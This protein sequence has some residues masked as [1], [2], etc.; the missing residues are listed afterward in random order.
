[1]TPRLALAAQLLFGVGQAQEAE[2]GVVLFRPSPEALVRVLPQVD[3]TRV[4]LVVHENQA[5]L[6]QQ[7]E[8]KRTPWVLDMDAWSVGGGTWFMVFDLAREDLGVQVTAVPPRWELRLVPDGRTVPPPPQTVPVRL[9]IAGDVA[10]QPGERGLTSLH[11]LDGD[12]AQA[13]LDATTFTPSYPVWQPPKGRTAEAELLAP[14]EGDPMRAIDRYRHVLTG[15]KVPR[16]QAMALYQLGHAHLDAGLYR[17]AS[18]YLGRLDEF[19]GHFPP[20]HGRLAQSR[21]ALAAGQTDLARSRCT[22]AAS[23]GARSVHVLECLGSVALATG[24]PAPSELARA[25]AARTA[26]AE[27]LLLAAQLFQQDHRHGEARKLL[28]GV[29]PVLEGEL[30]AIARLSLGDSLFAEGDLDGARVAWG[31]VT[32]GGELGALVRERLRLR[33]M[34][35]AGPSAWP[36]WLPELYRA[37]RAEGPQGAEALYTLSQVS[38]M[39]GDLDGAADHLAA[40]LDRYGSSL[41]RSD[42]P[43]RLWALSA[44][45]MDQLARAERQLELAAFHE[46]HYSPRLRPH[47]DDTGPLEGV[48][49]AYEALGLYEEALDV[50]REVFAIHTRQDRDEPGFLVTLARLYA[51]VGRL[52]ESLETLSYTRRVRGA[53]PWRGEMLLLEGQVLLEL[54]KVEDASKSWR[55]AAR[56]ADVKHE[57]GARLA[58]QDASTGRCDRAVPAL[59]GLVALPLS[60]QP[61]P[62]TD[63][64]AWLALARCQLDQGERDAALAS[65]RE[66]AGRSDDL[67][68]KRYATYLASLAGGDQGL[69][70]DALRSDEDLWAALGREADEDAAFEAELARYKVR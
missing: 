40:L 5:P 63:G 43:A 28:A 21:A 27:S 61:L 13:R 35:E 14:P 18:H 32:Q 3:P 70:D 31:S 58:L 67:L 6:D 41:E 53:G 16:H 45:R 52:D 15:S 11:P 57:A 20:I 64:R 59:T 49:S 8:G 34:V 7:L 1:M 46:E 44:R 54:G 36:A 65:A 29:V 10:R 26:R 47:V 51:R 48:A 2:D 39:L 19:E 62:V 30:S 33:A 38:E 23:V 50:S 9:L 25:L 42:V 17:E 69:T 22:E 24:G 66:A 68:H 37:A 55:E 12:V 60:E 4:E 56:F